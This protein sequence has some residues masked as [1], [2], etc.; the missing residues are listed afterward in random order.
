[1]IHIFGFASMIFTLL[2]GGCKDSGVDPPPPVIG[3]KKW[4]EIAMFKNVDIRYMIQHKGVLYVSTYLSIPA[5][6]STANILYKTEDGIKW[7]TL[8]T[9]AITIGPIA[10]YGDTLTIL[11]SG[12]TWKYHPTFGWKMFWKHLIAADHTRDMVWLNDQLFVFDNDF[13]LVYSQDTVR[14]MR[15]LFIEPSESKF[16]R[17]NYKGK[18]VV[19]TRPYYVYED[20]ISRFYGSSFE[21][22]MNGISA[23]ENKRPNYPAMHVYNDSFYA[24]FNTPSR[25]KKLVN[26][27]WTNVTDTIPNTPYANLFSPNLINRPTSIVFHQN[28]MFVGTEWTGVLEWSDSGWVSIS[29][30]LRLAFPDYPQYKLFSAVVQLESFKGKLFVAYGEPWYAPVVGGRGIYY[31]TFE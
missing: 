15:D 11:E 7:D 17:H 28:R 24:G 18:E 1:M 19:Y 8:K 20:K 27:V 2:M 3:E 5:K 22:I 30:D 6:D 26:D 16:V 25:I 10:F 12:R 4:K 23:D 29:T 21:I 9:F 31:F 14:V 13:G